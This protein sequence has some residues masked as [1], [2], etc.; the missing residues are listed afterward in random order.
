A[1]CSSSLPARKVSNSLPLPKVSNFW[2]ADSGSG[3]FFG[4]D[5]ETGTPTT[6][7]TTVPSCTLC[8][9]IQSIGIYGAEDAAQ[10][11]LTQLPPGLLTTAPTTTTATFHFNP[12]PQG[13]P[14]PNDDNQLQVTGY[15]FP[16]TGFTS[17]ALTVYASAIDPASG[18]SDSLLTPTPPPNAPVLVPPVPCTVATS[19]GQCVVWQLDNDELPPVVSCATKPSTC[20]F[21]WVKLDFF[22]ATDKAAPNFDP[23]NVIGVLDE[24]Y[25]ATASP[26][27]GFPKVK[28]QLSQ[29]TVAPQVPVATNCTYVSPLSPSACFTKSRTNIPVKFN[30]ANLPSG[31]TLADLLP[32]LHVFQ[33]FSPSGNEASLQPLQGTG[34]TTNY[35]LTSGQWNFNLNNPGF[36][37]TPNASR[38]DYQACTKDA[39]GNVEF[40]CTAFSVK[41]SCP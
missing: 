41:K 8:T 28:C 35:R 32:F 27:T 1:D 26:D 34:G 40:F 21:L 12:N 16:T 22:N 38:A 25:D 20:P 13:L 36:G 24:Q 18:F 3:T 10:P 31:K 6:F 39:S 7:S 5:F 30:C 29:H 9:G 17:L 15:N 11:G 14:D 19:T 4:L 23:N 33:V 2:L 37:Y